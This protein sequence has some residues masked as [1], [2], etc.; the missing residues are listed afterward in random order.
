MSL[1]LS[2]ST[3][4][5]PPQSCSSLAPAAYTLDTSCSLSSF[6]VSHIVD[7]LVAKLRRLPGKLRV[8]SMDESLR[9]NIAVVFAAVFAVVFAAEMTL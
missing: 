8:P 3:A 4:A 9:G 7:V 2:S 5:E 6:Q 1:R